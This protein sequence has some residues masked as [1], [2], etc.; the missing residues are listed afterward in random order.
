MSAVL[1]FSREGTELLQGILNSTVDESGHISLPEGIQWPTLNSSVLFVR[2]FYKPCFE[3]ALKSLN[4]A[5]LTNYKK[6]I[7]C[8]NPGIGKS[9]FG[10]YCLH[11][12]L[13]SGRTVVYQ[14]EKL[15]HGWL[16][17]NGEAFLFSKADLDKLE[18]LSDCNTVFLSDS[19]APPIVKAA[20]LLITS[21]KR[22]RWYEFRKETD[23]FLM[24]FPVF[25]YEEI[26]ACHER[27]FPMLNVQDVKERFTK[28][29]GI[30]RYVL[31]KIHK[32]E[33]SQLEKAF[34]LLNLDKLPSLLKS[35]EIES[36]DVGS[37]RLLHM[38]IQGEMADNTTQPA[39]LEYYACI[40]SELGSS[41]IKLRVLQLAEEFQNERVLSLISHEDSPELGVL[42]GRAFEPYALKVI[43]QGGSFNMR[44]LSP[45]TRKKGVEIPFE[46]ETFLTVPQSTLSIFDTLT[47]LKELFIANPNSLL[48]P[49]SKTLAS[50]DCI[51]SPKLPAN[52][53]VGKAHPIVLKGL[54]NDGLEE[55]VESLGYNS[56]E[57]VKFLFLLPPVLYN[58]FTAQPL[59]VNDHVL[60][61]KDYP[62]HPL[63]NRIVQ[64][65]VCIPVN[66]Q[67]PA[68]SS[69][70]KRLL[71][72]LAQ[73]A[74]SFLKGC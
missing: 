69:V 60:M 43:A 29:G 27:C 14:A 18:D 55:I 58:N 61:K 6:F 5:L 28:W 38:K 32:D 74:V 2:S 41:Y 47:H 7:I 72:T 13:R 48:A 66:Q 19:I 62:K 12:A 35:G 24:Y 16:F 71:G 64:Y 45:L 68:S 63:A 50:T 26:L 70:P 25:S 44:R 9:A 49:K 65:A 34:S 59:K 21:P 17:K 11:E 1:A 56:T 51:I 10:F 3:G 30:L 53:T 57:P 42:R 52:F 20:T 31:A 15:L 67:S 73:A 39:D 33:Q 4:Y 22:T 36:D 54:K 37:H 46:Q 40:R 23:C 8:G